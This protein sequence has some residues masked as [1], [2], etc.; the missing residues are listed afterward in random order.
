[1]TR[2]AKSAAGMVTAGMPSNYVDLIGCAYVL[3]DISHELINGDVSATKTLVFF[4]LAWVKV[5]SHFEIP[6]IKRSIVFGQSPDFTTSTFI[7]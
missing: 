5:F 6:Q 1:M 2:Y 4:H 7:A 3:E